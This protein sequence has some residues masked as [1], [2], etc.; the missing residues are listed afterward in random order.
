MEV[1]MIY[2]PTEKELRLCKEALWV[3]MGKVKKAE[4]PI[5][6]E[7]LRK[8][9]IARHS[10]IRVLNFGFLIEDIPSNISTHLARHVHAIPFISSLR[11]DRQDEIDGD[12][13]PRNTPVDMIFYCNAEELLTIANKRLCMKAS[14]KTREAVRMMCNE[15]ETRF[16]AFKGL[17]V[18]NCEWH[19]GIC[20]EKDGCGRY[21]SD[22]R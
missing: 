20:H 5:S 12:N 8:I 2:Y 7:L 18:P 1:T 13:A 6:D 14:E 17:F 15:V 3:T 19:N 22:N 21:P 11:N 16:P 4:T 9:L 10:P